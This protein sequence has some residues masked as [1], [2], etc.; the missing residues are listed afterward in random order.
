MHGISRYIPF[1]KYQ[2]AYQQEYS[3]DDPEHHSE[4]HSYQNTYMYNTK[5]ST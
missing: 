4:T 5:K 3:Y 2:D 1:H